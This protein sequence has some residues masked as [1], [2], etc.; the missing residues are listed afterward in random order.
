[1]AK[2]GEFHVATVEGKVWA[3]L[4]PSC[5]DPGEA[6]LHEVLW[7][8]LEQLNLGNWHV[9]CDHNGR[10]TSL[11]IGLSAAA[12][13]DDTSVEEVA[14]NTRRRLFVLNIVGLFA[15]GREEGV[16]PQ[17]SDT[18][19]EVRMTAT[20]AAYTNTEFHYAFELVNVLQRIR[21]NSFVFTAPPIKSIA[22]SDVVALVKEA[23]RAYLFGLRRSCVSLCRALI[24]AALRERVDL[25]ELLTERIQSKNGEVECLINVAAR[26]RI[27][28]RKLSGLAHGIRIAGNRALHG[29]EPTDSEAWAVL[30]D[31][32]A[33]VELVYSQS[34]D[35]G[36][37]R[38][39][40]DGRE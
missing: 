1:M 40:A 29:A 36:L 27:L 9:T 30:L 22:G 37:T 15:K 35:G 28:T 13:A 5:E 12:D 14:D 4:R 34:P 3:F 24:E 33:V 11:I 8:V 31:T 17:Y 21:E 19:E 16:E 20:D 39:A 18:A 6:P 23:T 7:W 10:G 2:T 25:G 38:A 26:R 32:R